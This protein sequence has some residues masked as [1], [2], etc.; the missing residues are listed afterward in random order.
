MLGSAGEVM[1]RRAIEFVEGLSADQRRAALHGFDEDRRRDWHYVPRRRPGLPLKA[2][3]EAQR[4]R[5]WALV[6]TALS[7]TGYRKARG[8]VD[9]EA[10][11]GELTGEVDRRDRL[12][13]AV[14]LFG[15]PGSAE[16]WSWR[17]EGH[18]L[19]LTFTIV[20]DEGVA[21]T[22]TFFGANPNQVPD[23]HRHAGLRILADEQ[24]LAFALVQGLEAVQREAA[25]IADR[26]MGDI[27]TGPGRE[28]SLRTPAGLP[29]ADMS[30]AQRDGMMHLLGAYVG[31]MEQAVA[32]R[33]WTRIR[34][35]GVERL[36]FAW[37][38]SLA[39]GRPHYYRIHGPTLVIEYDNTQNGANHAHS[40]WH[41]PQDAFGD[42]LLRRHHEDAHRGPHP[43][44]SSG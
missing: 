5:A 1:T 16:P 6:G 33:Q 34:E 14:A 29:L 10:I 27:L 23:G 43:S 37:A 18:H 39:P 38:G 25:V 32:G 35:A 41:D 12:N 13:Y 7:E 9:L 21:A 40:V 44:A 31:N 19:S 4:E 15:T 26:S 28:Q 2:M 30:E 36:H 20:P 3:D 8:V 42:D 11:L 17:V 24:D 22:P